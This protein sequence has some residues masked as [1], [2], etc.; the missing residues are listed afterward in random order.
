M[1]VMNVDDPRQTIHIPSRELTGT[2]EEKLAELDLLLGQ[3][4]VVRLALC[5]RPLRLES[6]TVARAEGR[7]DNRGWGRLWHRRS[8]PGDRSNLVGQGGRS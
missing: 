5:G 4:Q 8:T 7:R 6:L 2:R 1:S 3:L